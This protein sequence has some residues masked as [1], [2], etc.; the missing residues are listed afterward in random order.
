[1]EYTVCMAKSSD[2]ALDLGLSDICKNRVQCKKV[3]SA[4]IFFHAFTRIYTGPRSTYQWMENTRN[5]HGAALSKIPDYREGLLLLT[6]QRLVQGTAT[7][8]PLGHWLNRGTPG[9]VLV[10][11]IRIYNKVSKWFIFT[12]IFKNQDSVGQTRQDKKKKAKTEKE[13]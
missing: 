7:S 1:M 5:H 13:R 12:I 4:P 10:F 8:A 6:A 11:C 2:L 3:G 9:P